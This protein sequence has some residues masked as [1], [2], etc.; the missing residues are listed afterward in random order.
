MITV[1]PE[2]GYF[3]TGTDTGIGKTVVSVAL[4]RELARRGY[5]VAGMKPVA[6]GAEIQDGILKNADALAL[7]SAA[8]V[9]LEYQQVNPYCFA[10]GIAPNIA[11]EQA[12]VH[13]DLDHLLACRDAASEDVDLLIVEGVGG[14]RVPL[15]FEMD[16]ADLVREFAYPCI[17][18]V[19]ARL[20][21]INHALMTVDA[22]IDAGCRLSAWLS[23]GIDPE[24]EAFQESIDCLCGRIPSPYLGH[25][26]FME[27]PETIG[28]SYTKPIVDKLVSP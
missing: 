7:M 16:V 9:D 12:G 11:A 6:S 17:L 4:I 5:R 23:T 19:G 27:S 21:C 10:P 20:G 22:I 1:I 3:I 28:S 26:P 2:R 8:N 14:W 13:I 18:V 15:S 25:I 24:Y